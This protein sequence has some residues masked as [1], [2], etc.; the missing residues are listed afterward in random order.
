MPDSS[1]SL[2]IFVLGL[3]LLVSACYLSRDRSPNC[4]ARLTLITLSLIA[5][6]LIATTIMN[7]ADHPISPLLAYVG[8]IPFT[9]LLT[10]M[11]SGVAEELGMW[12]EDTLRRRR[13]AVEGAARMLANKR[14]QHKKTALRHAERLS[15]QVE[16]LED[17]LSSAVRA[18]HQE[19]KKKEEFRRALHGP[20]DTSRPLPEQAGDI[21][22]G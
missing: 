10:L 13:L 6:P 5:T 2:K 7:V 8:S 1:I 3:L 18:A 14:Q 9:A 16:Q 17:R 19:M 20:A 12:R 15:Q 11:I 21:L 22:Y 4:W